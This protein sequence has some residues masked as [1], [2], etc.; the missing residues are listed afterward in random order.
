M[1]IRRKWLAIVLALVMILSMIG[2]V[3]AKES[4]DAADYIQQMVNY[5]RYYQDA[6]DTDIDCLIYALSEVDLKQAQAWASIMDYWSY[7]NND[8]TIYPDVLPDGLPKTSSLCI[9]VLGYQLSA[10]GSMRA[11]LV[12]RLEAA[13]ASAQKY[14][15]ALIVCSGGGTAKNNK[16]VTEAG[17]M[18]K[19]LI[20]KGISEDRIIIEDQSLSTTGNAQN[21]CR[22]LAKEYPQVT[23]LAIVTSDYHLPRA[24]L[25]FHAQANLSVADGKEPLC[26]AANAAFE[27]GISAESLDLQL[28]NL[29]ALSGVKINGMQQPQL[30]KLDCILVSGS[31]QC[32]SGEE[33]NLQVIA[34]YD[35]GLYQD[36]THQ[37]QYTDL[38]PYLYEMQDVTVTYEEDDIKASSTVKI[39]LLPPETEPPTE[40]PTEVPTEAATEPATEP[41]ET[42]PE[43]KTFIGEFFSNKWLILPVCVIA[44]LLVAEV[45]I[46]SRLV[47]IRKQEK[48]AKAAEA[49]EKE[50]EKLPDDDSPLEY[51]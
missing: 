1:N 42:E 7:V 36:V 33:P 5:Y 27:T 35:T 39:E 28:D 11:E 38:F 14:P 37:A 23:H 51:I 19:W 47:K 46:I 25:L 31:A 32:K 9:V 30:S 18:A 24:C 44:L 16:T 41:I 2:T 4:A 15:E 43:H 8:M 40:A 3:S 34:Y 21:T 10:S 17:Q 6:A 20:E 45:L 12:C 26:V 22:I 13:L 49:A 48:A 29:L 50:A